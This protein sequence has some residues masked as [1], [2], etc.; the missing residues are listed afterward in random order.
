V[1]DCVHLRV[2]FLL[3]FVDV[4]SSFVVCHCLRAVNEGFDNKHS[5]QDHET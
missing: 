3:F 1:L 2:V 4:F 5:S